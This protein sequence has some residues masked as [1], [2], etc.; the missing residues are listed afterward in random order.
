M[1]IFSRAPAR[2]DP[3]VAILG[4]MILAGIASF[5]MMSFDLSMS[6]EPFLLSGFLQGMG[7]GLMFVALTTTAFSTL[8]PSLRAEGS[9]LFSLVRGLGS[10]IGVSV[11]QGLLVAN[12]AAMHASLAA[13]IDPGNPVVRAD[14]G[15][16][17]DLTTTAGLASAD[18]EI[19]RQALMIS[20]IDDFKLLLIVAVACLPLLLF[21]RRPR[22]TSGEAVH[23][24]ID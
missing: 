6:T 23:V 20:Y 4:G 16:R 10:S 24:A 17:F 7:L 14:I 5:Q 21:M 2:M 9:S 8:P 12:A 15:Q 18:G 11:T 22:A 19:T 3:R 13:R 1:L